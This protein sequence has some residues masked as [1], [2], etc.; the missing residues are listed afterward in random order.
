MC[1]CVCLC[2]SIFCSAA[3]T[4]NSGSWPILFKVLLDGNCPRMLW[5]I[6][7]KSWKQHPKKQQLYGH[8]PPISKTIQIRWIKHPGHCWRSKDELISDVLLWT[9]SH[10][11]A[12]IGWPTRTYLLQFYMD[13]GC[14]LEDLLETMNDRVNGERESGKS[15]QAA[16]HD[17]IYIYKQKDILFLHFTFLFKKD[18]DLFVFT[19]IFMQSCKFYHF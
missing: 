14:S 6:L 2:V 10:R 17:D 15:V 8:L 19:K 1:V 9:P 7:N 4:V 13:T 3:D 11:W 12:S 16:W 18:F 5:A